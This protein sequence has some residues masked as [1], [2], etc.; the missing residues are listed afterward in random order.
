MY[1]LPHRQ[2]PQWAPLGTPLTGPLPAEPEPRREAVAARLLE[3]GRVAL[4][5][6]DADAIPE[7]LTPPS[8][9]DIPYD[10]FAYDIDRCVRL[11]GELL[12]LERLCD[13]E[14]ASALWQ[15]RVDMPGAAD[16]ILAGSCCPP[17]FSGHMKYTIATPPAMKEAFGGSPA[18][19]FSDDARWCSAFV[20]LRDTLDDIVAV[21][22][23]CAELV[24]VQAS[25]AAKPA[26]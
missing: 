6:V 5:L 12:R 17:Q 10:S 14:P 20:P 9:V 23:L 19:A 1:E 4:A 25:G 11:K 7:L 8:R 13:L 15:L 26:G 21:L 3:L 24:P 18:V 22:E 2:Y 16:M